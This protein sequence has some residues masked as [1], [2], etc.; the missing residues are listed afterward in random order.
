M[1]YESRA[2]IAAKAD[3]E[4]GIDSL[5]LG[6]GFT[7]DDVPEGDTELADA[8]REML[9]AASYYEAA[10]DKFEALLPEPDEYEG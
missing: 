2:H 1:S 5:V 10:R 6:Y 3:W 9:A 7:V 8:A 4:G